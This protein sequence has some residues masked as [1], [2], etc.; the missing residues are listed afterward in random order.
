MLCFFGAA[1]LQNFGPKSAPIKKGENVGSMVRLTNKNCKDEIIFNAS[2]FM[3][4]LSEIMAPSSSSSA[5][6]IS[7]GKNSDLKQK[8]QKK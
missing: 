7:Y 2:I 4:V 8:T 1:N 6:R 5:S 3:R